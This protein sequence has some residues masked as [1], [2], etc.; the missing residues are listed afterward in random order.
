MTE[1]VYKLSFAGGSTMYFQKKEHLTWATM[2]YCP[3]Q[4]KI[5]KILV[6][7]TSPEYLSAVQNSKVE[8]DKIDTYMTK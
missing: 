2:K 5:K 3:N 6:K 4:L 8:D 1:Y 7:T